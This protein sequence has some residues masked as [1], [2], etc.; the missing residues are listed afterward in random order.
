LLAISATP[1]ALAAEQGNSFSIGPLVGYRSGGSFDEAGTGAN[2]KLDTA[3]SYG[4]VADFRVSPE[5]EV[6]LL[7]SH[8]SSQLKADVP[9]SVPLF[10]VDIDYIH[11]GGTYLFSSGRMQPFFAATLGATLFNPHRDGFD[12]ETKFSFG[13]GGGVKMPLGRHFGLR[14]EARAYGTVLD[15]NSSILCSGGSCLINAAGTVLWQYEANAGV[16]LSF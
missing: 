13:V 8:Q 7:W 5:T 12:N 3:K 14:A 2:L 16:Y 9:V 15:G 1:W 6:E 4:L 11:L 10:D